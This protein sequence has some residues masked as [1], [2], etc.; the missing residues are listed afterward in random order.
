LGLKNQILRSLKSEFHEY[1]KMGLPKSY[2]VAEIA[3]SSSH[4]FC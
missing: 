3:V 1:N 2:E 4:C